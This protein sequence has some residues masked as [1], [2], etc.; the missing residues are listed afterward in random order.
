MDGLYYTKLLYQV[1]VAFV[2]FNN[3]IIDKCTPT[4]EHVALVNIDMVSIICKIN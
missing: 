1:N 3:V 4:C 2:A